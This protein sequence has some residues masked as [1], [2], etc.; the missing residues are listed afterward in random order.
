MIMRKSRSFVWHLLLQLPLLLASCQKNV[1]AQAVVTPPVTTTRWV[2]TSH[3]DHLYQPVKLPGGTEV[4]TVGIYSNYPNYN[5]VGDADEGFTCVDDIA[6][7]VLF[8]AHEPDLTTNTDKQTKLRKLTEFV[9]QLQSANGYFYNFLFPDLTIN[10]AGQTSV[11]QANWWSW[12]ALWG[13]TEAYPFLKTLD[14]PLADRI[15]VAAGR[16]V[17]N[18]IRDFGSKPL[19][20]TYVKG[21]KVPTWLPFGSGSDQAAVMLLGL[22]NY[23]QQTTTDARVGALMAQ[24]GDGIV[25]MQYGS[26]QQFPYG[27]VLSFENNWH[28]YGSDQSYALLRVGKA[29]GKANWVAAAQ[30]EVDTFYPYLL[31]EGFLESFAI[32]QSGS[33]VAVLSKSAFAQIAYGIRP[34]IWATLELYD[35]TK[36]AKYATQATQ[37]AGWFLGSNAASTRMYDPA[38]GRCFDGISSTSQVNKNSGAESTI[39]AL[40]AFQRIEQYPAVMTQ[41]EKYR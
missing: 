30:F 16:V 3:L 19:V 5:L 28:A 15:Q 17:G 25:A 37:L 40:W 11:D 7:T 6:R 35:Q 23:Q 26:A 39:E 14:P 1:P 10:R 29:L 12:R 21:I 27:A 9:L 13:L 38:T 20:F 31:R 32:T 2:N 34:M 33:D 8:L 41:L 4:G 22:L 24:L 18:M 36:D